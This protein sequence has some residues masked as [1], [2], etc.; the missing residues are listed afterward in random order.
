MYDVGL[1]R[2]AKQKQ[3]ADA[4]HGLTK[5]LVKDLVCKRAGCLRTSGP[6]P[7]AVKGSNG[8]LSKPKSSNKEA[9]RR[10]GCKT[11]IRTALSVS[12]T[13]RVLQ[14]TYTICSQN[15]SS[16]ACSAIDPVLSSC[17]LP[18][19]LQTTLTTLI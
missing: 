10:A 13:E 12:S 19:D 9:I 15:T 5:G 17:G 8:W 7:Y 14:R 18:L 1:Y 4:A 16:P 2:L 11:D 6:W 3:H